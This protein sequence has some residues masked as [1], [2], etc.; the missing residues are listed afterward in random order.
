MRRQWL[1]M[2]ADTM[3]A[4]L[5]A[6]A[7]DH[8]DCD[9]DGLY[10]APKARDR[11]TDYYWFCLDH[12]R[13]YNRAWNYYAGMDSAEIEAHIREDTVWQRPSWPMGQWRV[14]SERVYEAAAGGPFGYQFRSEAHEDANGAG[15]PRTAE[16]EALDMLD[17]ARPVSLAELKARYKQLV[18]NLHPDLNGADRM[19]EERLKTINLAYATLKQ[20]IRSAAQATRERETNVR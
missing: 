2:T 3:K 18:K 9:G 16:Q 15:R 13:N 7:C 11:L 20:S 8:P 17:L 19:A 6:R 10:R 14:Y 4:P 12:V 1:D 5:Q